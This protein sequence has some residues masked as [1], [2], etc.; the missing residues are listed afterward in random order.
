[1]RK[2]VLVTGGFDP[3]HSGHIDYFASAKE[4]GD[5]LVV[6]INSDEWLTRKKGRPFMPFKE[7]LA[8]I[9]QLS[10]VDHTISFDDS[11]DTACGAIF[12]TMS[13][14]SFDQLIF[15]NGGDRTDE[16]TPEE[17]TYK[18]NVKFVYGVGGTHKKNSSSWILEDWKSPKTLRN[19]GWYR[20]LD[21]KA[22]YK[23]KELVIN[24]QSSLSTQRHFKRSEHWYILKGKCSIKTIDEDADSVDVKQ[25]HLEQNESFVIPKGVWHQGINN[26]S[27][28]CHILEVQYGSECVESDIQ[29]RYPESYTVKEILQAVD[30]INS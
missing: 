25:K 23:V 7:R 5:M 11:D 12:K 29:R 1:M 27:Q 3:L 13:T 9:N 8:I 6:G 15:A 21:D 2:V 20:V 19:W 14:M 10:M 24:P 22:G 28:P 26:Q 30:D 18:D 17:L 16:N 4:L